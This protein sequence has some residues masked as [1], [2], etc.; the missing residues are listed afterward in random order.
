MST[1][2]C[3]DTQSEYA[4]R[5]REEKSGTSS[6]QGQDERRGE[7]GHEQHTHRRRVRR[8]KGGRAYPRLGAKDLDTAEAE[9]LLPPPGI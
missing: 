4:E 3:R 6:T 7:E 5:V 9:R 1:D 2:I 8:V